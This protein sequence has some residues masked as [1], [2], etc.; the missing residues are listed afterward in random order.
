M[1]RILPLYLYG[2][3]VLFL[4]VVIA[5]GAF[6]QEPLADIEIMAVSPRTV[7][8]D[9][10]GYYDVASPGLNTVGINSK[11]YLHAVPTQG[12]ESN[13]GSYDWSIA[14]APSGSG[15]SLDDPTSSVVSFRPDMAGVFTIQLVT[16]DLGGTPTLAVQTN[17]VAA[18]Y[19]GTGTVGDNTPSFPQCDICHHSK[20]LTWQVTGH[21][22]KLEEVMNGYETNHYA[23]SCLECHTVG[24]DES[25]PNNGNFYD[26]AQLLSYDLNQIPTLAN[27]AYTSRTV[28]GLD[29]DTFSTLPAELQNVANIQCEN[30][31]GPGSEHKGDPA[32][33]AHG[34]LD[35]G[36]CARCHDS[37]TGHQQIV[38]QWSNSHHPHTHLAGEGHVQTYSSCFKCHIGEGFIEVTVDGNPAPATIENP[39]PVACA[40][41]HDPHSAENEHQLRLVG[42][43]TLPS[44]DV[45]TNAGLGGLCMNC[46]N[47]RVEDMDDT[48]R[49]NRRGAHHGPQADML[50]GVNAFDFGY[51]YSEGNSMHTTV[52][53][54]TCVACHMADPTQS[55]TGII[56]PPPVGGHTWALSWDGGTPGNPA[57]DVE[58]AENA[59]GS[60]HSGLT[61]LNRTANGDYD[62]DGTVEGIQSEVTGLLDILRPE[63]LARFAGTQYDAE[64]GKISIGSSDFDNL[65]VEQKGV[66][67]NYNFVAEDG[68]RGVHNT[69]YAIQVL[70]RTYGYLM[71]TDFSV[72][73]PDADIRGGYQ[74]VRFDFEDST[75]GWAF[76]SPFVFD[77]PTTTGLPGA[78]GF[79]A[80]TNT[81]TFG[82]WSSADGNI[83]FVPG[84]IYRLRA[85][86]STDVTDAN[87]VPQLRLRINDNVAQSAMSLV[88]GSSGSAVAVPVPGGT[89]YTELFYPPQGLA[90]RSPGMI[91]SFDILNFDPGD[92]PTGTLLLDS[93]QVDTLIPSAL[94]TATSVA[95]YTF[96]TTSE[97]WAFGTAP[98]AFGEPT[99][100][101]GAGALVLTAT[102]NTSNFGFWTSPGV[103][104]IEA[105]KIYRATFMVST[106]LTDPTTVPQ[107][108][109]RLFD[110]TSQMSGVL[111]IASSNT[112]ESAPGT[113]ATPY[114][115]YLLPPD[116]LAGTNV[117]LAFDLLN[118]DPGDSATGSLLLDSVNL[119]SFSA[120]GI[121]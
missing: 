55:G 88:A 25:A 66:L 120:T 65:S 104:P 14:S 116:A 105:N 27:A 97:G 77:S 29:P 46:H 87:Q 30:C 91:I 53:T 75:Q 38:Y 56:T 81:S 41:C 99:S 102:S 90:S 62:G 100:G 39:H 95:S 2:S 1:K 28:H 48:V 114:E 109:M 57:D 115:V 70:Q 45:F 21:G 72:A 40:A 111:S 44:G 23:V 71:H 83:P 68:S 69:S 16:S 32:K 12:N 8:L 19:I 79:T 64:E 74:G 82:F 59:C 42:D 54:D 113:T 24:Y 112:A 93:V 26:V 106:N 9:T 6:A 84:R 43:T 4:M 49:T 58:N 17:I 110:T 76:D 15:A 31:H 80:T 78:I 35:V 34:E 50:L 96:D 73:Y 51:S 3:I 37:A 67:Y 119:E 5:S 10:S 117:G 94:G 85:T 60:C 89:A 61:T 52:V 36:R 86:V 47:S 11:T 7:T 92:S 22:T 33:I 121:R 98:L 18:S 108:R 103:A 20:V 118:F 101:S 63:I 13:I 107:A